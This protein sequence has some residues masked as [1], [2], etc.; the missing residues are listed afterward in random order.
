MEPELPRQASKSEAAESS[1]RSSDTE[2][3][4]PETLGGSWDP[5]NLDEGTLSS[6]EQEGRIAAKEISR[7][8]VD[9]GAAMPAPSDGEIVMLK[10]RIDRGFS[11]PPSYFLKGVLR[12]YRLQL[13]HIASNSFTIIAG[14]VMLCEGY[15]GIN[16]RRDLFHLYFNIRHNRDA[17]GDPRN[18]RSVS[19]VPQSGKSYPYITPHDS[20]KGWRG[21]FFYQADQAPPERNYGLRSFVDGPAEEQDSWGVMDDFTMDDECQLCSRRILKLVFSGLTGAD[22]IHYWISRRIQPLQYRPALM[23]EYSRIDDPQRY[24]KE[25][26]SAEEIEHQIRNIIKV[27]RDEP[28]KLKIPMY[29]NDNC[30][31]VSAFLFRHN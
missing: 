3:A 9:P 5:C 6:L 27:G 18:C 15:L 10:S 2:S 4:I 12:H 8:R 14:F 17:N 1:A 31:E 13:H 26:L 7:W 20:A 25:E 22:T 29:G 19:F 28:L 24:S 21:S 11:L 30:P 23:C 16:P